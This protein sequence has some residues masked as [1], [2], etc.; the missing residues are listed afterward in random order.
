MANIPQP[1]LTRWIRLESQ[2]MS[3]LSI[4][5]DDALVSLL[6]GLNQPVQRSARELMVLELYRRGSVSSGKAAELL[7]VSRP[8]FIRHASGLGIS[9]MDMTDAEW[10]DERAAGGALG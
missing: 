1:G 2:A 8:D 7:G 4:Q 10:D 6:Q 9:F 5:L 3:S